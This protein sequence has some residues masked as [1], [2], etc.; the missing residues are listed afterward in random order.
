MPPCE[1]A[2]GVGGLTPAP[3]I[4]FV[5]LSSVRR[6]YLSVCP[7]AVLKPPLEPSGLYLVCICPPFPILVTASSSYQ[8][9]FVTKAHRIAPFIKSSMHGN[10]LQPNC[11]HVIHTYR[12]PLREHERCPVGA[13][14]S[15]FLIPS[16]AYQGPTSCSGHHDLSHTT[17]NDMISPSHY[18]V[19][20]LL[21]S[22]KPSG[23]TLTVWLRRLMP[24]D[25][26]MLPNRFHSSTGPHDSQ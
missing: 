3:R 16:A 25:D 4:G 22:E 23:S 6:M 7:H 15:C 10:S 8:T 17:P 2:S 11:E 21:P 19:N 14:M 24:A 9:W 20:I 26:A 12:E 1:A 5:R 18:A 13:M